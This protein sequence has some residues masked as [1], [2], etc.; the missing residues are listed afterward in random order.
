MTVP[1]FQYAVDV[2]VEVEDAVEVAVAVD[3]PVDEPV[4]VLVVAKMPVLSGGTPTPPA[5]PERPAARAKEA[6]V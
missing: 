5:L 6:T 1:T 2:D 4:A 3:E